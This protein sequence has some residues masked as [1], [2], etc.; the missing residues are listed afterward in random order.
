MTQLFLNQQ[1]EENDGR[2]YIMI[3]SNESMRPGQDQTRAS[4]STDLLL[5]ALRG[6]GNICISCKHQRFIDVL[7]LSQKSL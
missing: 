5:I 1:K 4:G 7:K 2:K 6:P 3:K